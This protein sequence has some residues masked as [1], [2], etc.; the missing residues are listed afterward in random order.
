M[1]MKA[2]RKQAIINID[3]CVIYS[4]LNPQF[5]DYSITLFIY[6]YNRAVVSIG[7]GGGGGEEGGNCRPN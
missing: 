2:L 3:L 1:F 4:W 5:G 6:S 7:A